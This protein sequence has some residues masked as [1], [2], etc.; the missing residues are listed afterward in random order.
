MNVPWHGPRRAARG[1]ARALID[2]IVQ[3]GEGGC[4]SGPP[5]LIASRSLA[6]VLVG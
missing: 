2:A 4:P 6:P 3:R 5:S 1:L